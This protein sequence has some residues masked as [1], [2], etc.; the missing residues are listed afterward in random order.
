ETYA[1]AA[2][3]P[4][5]TRLFGRPRVGRS[6]MIWKEVFAEPGLR[7]GWIGR[8]VTLLLILASLVPLV[9]ILYTFYDQMIGGIR[10]FGPGGG[11]SNGGDPW[12]HL[13]RNTTVWV[14]IV[15]TMV[16][17]LLLMTIAV[18]AANSVTGE[19]DRRT[20]DELLTTPLSSFSILFAKWLG[21][22]CSV[23]WAWL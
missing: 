4:F 17:S 18:R 7:F 8:I 15:G 9:F 21:S 6:P 16:A 11:R 20:L 10:V 19:R 12:F 1:T 13:A 14:R 23:R 3:L 22:V 2:R 5:L